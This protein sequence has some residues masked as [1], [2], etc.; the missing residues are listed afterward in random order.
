MT[1]ATGWN[2]FSEQ[3][4]PVGGDGRKNGKPKD[5]PTLEPDTI[6]TPTD[7]NNFGFVVEDKGEGCDV[8][9][10]PEDGNTY[11]KYFHKSQLRYQDGTPVDPSAAIDIGPPVPLRKLV[12]DH[13][14]L[15]PP[16]VDGF[17]RRA[18][19]ANVVADPKRGKSWLGY[20]LAF[21]VADGFSWFDR[22]P[23]VQ[24]DVLLIDAELHPETISYRLPKAAEAAGASPD[25]VD[26]IEV[27]ALRGKGVDLFSLGQAIRKLPRNRYSLVLLDAWYRFLPPGISEN[28]NAAVMS[29]YNTIDGYTNH[30][31]AAWVNIHHASKGDQSAKGTTDV[32]SGAG[33]QSRA[34]DTHLIIRPHED[35]GVAVVDAVV[36]SFPPVESF[37]IQFDFPA[38]FLDR[39]ADVSRLRRPGAERKAAADA[40]G[41]TR[42]LSA[43]ETHGSGTA[44][45]LR[46]WTGIGYDRI[47]RLLV[48]MVAEG[49]LVAREI[50]VRG[51]PCEEYLLPP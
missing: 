47:Q 3:D 29:L 2:T 30:L 36:R 37:A 48:S 43:L 11:T 9:F 42:I 20:G 8:E 44:S 35:D 5:W 33:S 23:C 13:P 21:A 41:Q 6:V 39:T 38:W 24:G 14:R 27:W 28:D 19:V 32:G 16:V 18:E 12:V 22:F 40:D 25:C 10:R 15:R 4:S 45:R 34:A 31:N 7:R 26:R 50:T 1:F 17:L 49:V 51:N 46:A